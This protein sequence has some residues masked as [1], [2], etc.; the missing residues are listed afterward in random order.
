MK[1]TF[2]L[3]LCLFG[4]LFSY[5]NHLKGGWIYY[6][7]LGPG[8]SPN[9]VKYQITVKQYLDCHSMGQQ[10]DQTVYLG[11]FSNANNQLT[12][13]VS[14]P[15]AG[16]DNDS[17][18]RRYVNPCISSPPEVCYRIDRYVTT[19][20]LPSNTAGYTLAVQRCCRIAG[21]VNV[22][23]SNNIGVSYTTSIPGT[24]NGLN[25]EKNNSPQFVQRDTVMV[26]Y[27]G[28]F[29]FDFGATDADGDSLTY[30]FCPG[31]IGGGSGNNQSQPGAPGS[32]PISN[33][34]YASVP[35]NNNNNY[36]GQSP[37]SPAVTVDAKTGLISGRAP[38]QTGDYVVAVCASEFRNGVKIGETKK[39]IH[40]TVAN[41]SLAA[42]EL[43]QPGYQLCDDSTFTFQNLSTSSNIIGYTWSFGDPRSGANNTSTSPVPTHTYSGIGDYTIKLAVKSS[44]GCTDSTSSVVKVYP[45]FKPDFSFTGSCFQTPFRFQDK[46][47]SRYGVVNSWNW[48]FGDLSSSADTSTLKNPT[49]QYATPGARTARLIV[50]DSKGCIDTISK[51]VAVNDI[52]AL[53]L[54]FKDTLICSIDTL[55]LQSIGNGIFTWSPN[56]NIINANTANPLVYP[57]TTTSYVVTLNES[58][59]IKK[60]TIKVNVLDFITVDAGRDTS[61]C[62]TDTITLRPQSQALQYVWTPSTWLS[63][64]TTK[65]PVAQPLNNITYY[66]TANLGKCRDKDS[67]RIKVTPYPQANAGPDASICFGAQ[68]QLQATIVGSRFTWS[69][70]GSLQNANTLSP[71]AAPRATTSYLLAVFDT[72]GCP[73]PFIDTVVVNVTP[74]VKAFAGNDTIIVANQ[75]LQLNATGGISYLWT[76]ATGI[77][78][79][80]IPNPVVTLGP[81]VDSITYRVRVTV[82]DRCFAEDDIKVRIFK[83]GPDIL[84]PTAFTPNGDGKNDLLRP[85]PVG[86]RSMEYF[87]VYN[88]W[89]AL[90]YSTS[91]LGEGWDGTIAGKQQATGTF[92]FMTAA[93]DYLGNTITKKGTVVLIR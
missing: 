61:I 89:G 27:N 55:P 29:T 52:P 12:R 2:I 68:T 8:T 81:S 14:I 66:V 53:T 38:A 10:I 87:R 72:L 41:C 91:Q 3:L 1:K 33:P 86:I 88:R 43:R 45:G 40:I 37:M 83:T 93:I 39:E 77:S 90:V 49:Y 32:S 54:P 17:I 48:D 58:G 7:Y 30:S 73:K 60:D 69:P 50:G 74:Q 67:I 62:R 46:T 28:N 22:T 16:T 64:S 84:V 36:S 44:A 75:P 34:P 9:T 57:K 71:V 42:A 20:E 6:E 70:A 56:Y 82:A 59:C 24:I 85:I 51:P 47:T 23:G 4:W 78:D 11:I 80:N 79:P 92:V 18:I 26:C 15:L 63:N 25:F 13:Q 76:P 65:N 35:Y 5:S 21:I 19:V 31:L